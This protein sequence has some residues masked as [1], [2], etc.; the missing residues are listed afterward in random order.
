MTA[1][2]VDAAYW[3]AVFRDDDQW[4]PAARHAMDRLGE[5]KLVTTEEVLTEFLTALSRYGPRLRDLAAKAVR[6]IQSDAK[7][8]VLGQSHQSFADGLAR[9]E[10]RLD[11]SYSLQDCISMN[12]MEAEGI[13]EILTSD[14]HFEQE[15][16][17]I[18]MRSSP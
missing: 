14:H 2:F 3:I 18:L 17:T 8:Q 1:V 6:M 9:Y 5:T 7:I 4:N 15:G 16:F 12:V 11:K 10:S 13:A